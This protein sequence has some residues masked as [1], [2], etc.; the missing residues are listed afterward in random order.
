M[1]TE[2][3]FLSPSARFVGYTANMLLPERSV[4]SMVAIE[5][6]RYDPSTIVLSPTNAKWSFDHRITRRANVTVV[7]CKGVDDNGKIPIRLPQLYQYVHGVG[8]QGTIYVLPSQPPASAA[9]WERRCADPVCRNRYCRCCPRDE[10]SWSGLEDWMLPLAPVERLQPWFS[11]WAWCIPAVDLAAHLGVTRS[12]PTKVFNYLDWDD[13]LLGEIT[14]TPTRFFHRFGCDP[15]GAWSSTSDEA[16]VFSDDVG[17]VSL[18]LDYSMELEE[19]PPLLLLKPL[20]GQMGAVTG[21]RW[22]P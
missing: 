14:P 7:E 18:S 4:D 22:T 19:T 6:V 12:P 15:R 9:P 10:R 21:S 17:R 3:R 20:G 16:P 2:R 11:H 1:R 8:P 13:S 5:V